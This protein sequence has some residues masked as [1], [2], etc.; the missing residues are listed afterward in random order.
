MAPPVNSGIV[1][2][3]RFA[4]GAVYIGR[5]RMTLAKRL[6]RHLSKPA[7]TRAYRRLRAG[8][9]VDID[10]LRRRLD[11]QEAHEAEIEELGR[12]ENLLNVF[13]P[14]RN[15]GPGERIPEAKRM[16]VT[17][18]DLAAAMSDETRKKKS[19]PWSERK[20]YR[21][22]PPRP[23]VYRCSKCQR[24]LDW[25]RFSRDRSRFN[26]LDSRCRSCTHVRNYHRWRDSVRRKRSKNIETME[27]IGMK[28]TM[29]DLHDHL[30][31]QIERLSEED[32][33]YDDIER[34]AARA[35]A[36]TQVASAAVANAEAIIKAESL[37]LEYG[38]KPA[39]GRDDKAD[40]LDIFSRNRR[41]ANGE[42]ARK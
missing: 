16:P 22:S 18:F 8:M 21:V 2:R 27:K 38:G 3:L 5:T 37:R 40:V 12:A 32:M 4:D 34:E 9:R 7:N 42:A 10:V 14:G 33:T 6:E 17:A 15:G 25:R 13:M 30:I 29:S 26:G 31:A 24:W 28:N 36:I 20:V 35:K 23:G 39:A 11:A 19:K 1:Y 41:L